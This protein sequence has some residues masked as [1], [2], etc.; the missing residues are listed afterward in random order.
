M[1]HGKFSETKK[2]HFTKILSKFDDNW[3][4][5]DGSIKRA[6]EKIASERIDSFNDAINT[7]YTLQEII[8]FRSNNIR[9]I[10]EEEELTHE[11]YRKLTKLP[12]RA[13]SFQRFIY[14]VDARVFSSMLQAQKLIYSISS[15][16]LKVIV[17]TN[18]TCFVHH[19]IDMKHEIVQITHADFITSLK[20]NKVYIKDNGVKRIVPMGLFFRNDFIGDNTFSHSNI[21]NIP[22]NIMGQTAESY[23]RDDSND[24]EDI[25]QAERLIAKNTYNI[26]KPWAV[27]KYYVKN[28][29]NDATVESIFSEYGLDISNKDSIMCNSG[30][31]SGYDTDQ[32]SSSVNS[33]DFQNPEQIKGVIF[34][35]NHI[36]NIWCRKD[37]E[38]FNYIISIFSQIIQEPWNRPKIMLHV[39]GSQGS[40]KSSPVEFLCKYVFG[41][42]LSYSCK[43]MNE[44][45]GKFNSVIEGKLLVVLNEADSVENVSEDRITSIWNQ[46]KMVITDDTISIRRMR[47][48]PYSVKNYVTLINLT[49][50][51]WSAKLEQGDRRHLMIETDNSLANPTEDDPDYKEKMEIRI[52]YFDN[53]FYYIGIESKSHLP[54]RVAATLADALF[55][56]GTDKMKKKYPEIVEEFK[57]IKLT[58]ISKFEQIPNT[59]AR[60]YNI[61]HSKS[62]I[63]QYIDAVKNFDYMPVSEYLRFDTLSNPVPTYMTPY[64]LHMDYIHWCRKTKKNYFV[65][66]VKNFVEKL[67]MERNI[68]AL[69]RKDHVYRF[70]VSNKEGVKKG[71]R[72]CCR[73]SIDLTN[74]FG[75]KVLEALFDARLLVSELITEEQFEEKH[76]KETA[77]AVISY[78]NSPIENAIFAFY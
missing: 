70:S 5:K 57:D 21:S 74:I 20:Y 62:T 22:H 12:F 67:E 47:A 77:I 69:N 76:G 68:G 24:S 15:G 64:F 31:S 54:M 36:Y 29:Y 2:Q 33:F 61:S 34:F 23:N 25:N 11:M 59:L 37:P 14:L 6:N 45:V 72:T 32:S 51:P 38:L 26:F 56:W 52:K 44:I 50:F 48:D 28:E 60:K 63:G 3:F 9:T 58:K 78:I 66:D 13:I 1:E 65:K 75:I 7:D 49:N 10:D 19:I 18:Y 43:S 35:L 16:F 42:N 53:L 27:E 73:G 4:K 17:N 39:Q 46:I 41:Y 71:D 40:G 30:D 55:I 8:Q